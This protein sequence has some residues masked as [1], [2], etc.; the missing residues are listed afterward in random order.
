M[1]TTITILFLILFSVAVNAQKVDC[2]YDRPV[3][4]YFSKIEPSGY[5]G[6]GLTVGTFI[7]VGTLASQVTVQQRNRIALTCM[8][9]SVLT[10]GIMVWM[11]EKR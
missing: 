11:E 7:T 8:T 3:N 10:Y 2:E 1:K 5:V 6:I 9:V 4:P